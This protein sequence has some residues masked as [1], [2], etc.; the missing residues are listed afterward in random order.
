MNEYY[1]FLVCVISF[2]SVKIVQN[3]FNLEELL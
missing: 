2:T 1:I 3:Y